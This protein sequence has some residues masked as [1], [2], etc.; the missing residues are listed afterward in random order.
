LS[1]PR[2]ADNASIPFGLAQL[3]QRQRVIELAF[4]ALIGLHRIFE[5]GAFA[6]HFLRVRPLVPEIGILG[7]GVQF[8]QA[9]DGAIPVKDASAGAKATN[10]SGRRGF[11]F[12]HA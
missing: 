11:G 9:L 1:A 5:M 10:G 4:Q 12:R 8:R 2:P 3:D 6:H 7:A